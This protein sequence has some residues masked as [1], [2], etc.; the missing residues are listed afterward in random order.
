VE[1]D[2]RRLYYHHQSIAL[3]GR[4]DIIVVLAYLIAV[5]PK[6]LPEYIF[7]FRMVNINENLGG[8]RSLKYVSN[9]RILVLTFLDPIKKEGV[10]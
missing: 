4:F 6:N 10:V 5:L 2:G 3:F 1:E 8:E 7:Y 9:S